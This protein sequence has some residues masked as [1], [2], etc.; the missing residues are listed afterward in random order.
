[1][2]NYKNETKWDAKKYK[3]LTFKVD[4]LE[5]EKLTEEQKK[6]LNDKMRKFIKSYDSFCVA[7]DCDIEDNSKMLERCPLVDVE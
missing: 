4:R 3:R 7:C 2:R 6:A 5:Y 1:M